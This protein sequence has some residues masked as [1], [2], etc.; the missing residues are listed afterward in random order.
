MQPNASWKCYLWDKI[1][2]INNLV[3]GIPINFYIQLPVM[4][5]MLSYFLFHNSFF[6]SLLLIILYYIAWF[7]INKEKNKQEKTLAYIISC[8]KLNYTLI[9]VHLKILCSSHISELVDKCIGSRIHII[10]KNDKEIVGVLL[11][12]DDYVSIL[13]F[14]KESNWMW[15]F[16]SLY[17]HNICTCFL[18]YIKNSLFSAA[19]N[20]QARDT[21]SFFVCQHFHSNES[22]GYPN[23]LYS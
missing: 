14:K 12:F 17:V 19:T 7:N 3:S 9:I 18:H 11:G 2:N 21:V 13:S 5:W 8:I 1:G 4:L 10:M 20:L 6:D 22:E 15:L 23:L 16:F